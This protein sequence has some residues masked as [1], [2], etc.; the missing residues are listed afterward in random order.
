MEAT[1]LILAPA[2]LTA[3]IH[4]LS[5]ALRRGDQTARLE[6]FSRLSAM[7]GLDANDSVRIRRQRQRRSAAPSCAPVGSKDSHVIW[8]HRTGGQLRLWNGVPDRWRGYLQH[9]FQLRFLLTG[10]RADD[11][12]TEMVFG[13]Q[14]HRDHVDGRGCKRR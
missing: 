7:D 8:H 5:M 1:L 11:P 10:L 4:K 13:A 3:P 2:R 6:Q 9:P 12:I 14:R